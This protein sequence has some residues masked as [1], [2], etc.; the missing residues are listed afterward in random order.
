MQDKVYQKPCPHCR[1]DLSKQLFHHAHET[2][3]G[4]PEKVEFLCHEC[5]GEI[6][7]E[8]CW[9]VTYVEVTAAQPTLAPDAVP[10][11]DTAQ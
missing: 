11:S 10:A 4:Y 8:F 2:G 9:N 6:V 5:E 1:A 3:Y 7:V